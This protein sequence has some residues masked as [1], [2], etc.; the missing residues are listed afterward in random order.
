[1]APDRASLVLT[2]PHSDPAAQPESRLF[3]QPAGLGLTDGLC[4]GLALGSLVRLAEALGLPALALGVGV[5]VPLADGLAEVLGGGD[6]G[7]S[8]EPL[9]LGVGVGEAE[10]LGVGVVL[11]VGVGV[12]VVLGEGLG[13]CV[14]L[15]VGLAGA[16]GVGLAG[17]VGLGEGVAA[18]AGTASM[19]RVA[20]N[21]RDQRTL[22]IL[23]TSPVVG[24]CTILPL[25][26]YMPMWWI[27]V[28]LLP[29]A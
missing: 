6:V 15:G 4:V 10:A 13:V 12:G 9:V 14:G 26:M 19:T 1:M 28:Q 8:G 5:V 11:G 3:A 25:P 23:T 17:F 29:E 2:V 21:S 16:L 20:A 22:E 27:V 7:A 18:G 24:A